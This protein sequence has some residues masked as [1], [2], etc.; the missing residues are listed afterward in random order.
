MAMHG[1]SC[2]HLEL[3]GSLCPPVACADEPMDAWS[4]R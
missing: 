3:S 1:L 4:M 2:G